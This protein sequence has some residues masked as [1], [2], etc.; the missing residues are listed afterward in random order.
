M[1]RF[2]FVADHRNA[3]EVKR[4]CQLVD[5]C[6]SA[7]YAWAAAADA[8]TARQAADE[9]LADRIRAVHAA[10]PENRAYGAPR[11]TAEL[12]DGADPADRVNHKR[13]ARLMAEHRIAGIRLRRRVRTTIPEPADEQVPD[14]LER[15]FIADAPNVNYVGDITY[16][17]C[18]DGSTL[19]LATVIDCSS[20]RLAGWS[21]ADHMRTELVADALLAAARP[22]AAWPGRS[23]TAT[24]ATSTPLGPTPPCVTVS[25]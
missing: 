22:A 11:V 23:S 21:I 12:N 14:R 24:T 1:T 4:M 19:Y 7:L 3:F 20:R 2:Q 9:Q 18:V 5:V 16:L 15:D 6:R 10:E 25:G 13:V 8:R 17:P